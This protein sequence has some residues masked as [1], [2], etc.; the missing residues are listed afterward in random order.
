MSKKSLN[1]KYFETHKSCSMF[2][3]ID[4]YS[5]GLRL[6]YFISEFVFF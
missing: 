1:I 6:L 3:E 5:E 4:K 2:A